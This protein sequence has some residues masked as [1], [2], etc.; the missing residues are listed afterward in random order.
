MEVTLT[1]QDGQLD[2]TYAS[3][4]GNWSQDGNFTSIG[5]GAK[6]PIYRKVDNPNLY[7]ASGEV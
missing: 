4:L 1:L 2:S 7:L 6:R 5:P 3:L